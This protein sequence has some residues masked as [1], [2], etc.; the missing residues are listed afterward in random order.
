MAENTRRGLFTLSG[1][2]G[3]LIATALL[4]SILAGLTMWD[5]KVQQAEAKHYYDPTP[6]VSS[7]DNVKMISTDNAKYDI[8]KR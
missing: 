1:I 8:S 4:L 5:I 3:M 2:T 6:V 7:L